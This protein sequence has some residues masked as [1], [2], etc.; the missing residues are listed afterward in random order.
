MHVILPLIFFAFIPALAV[1]GH[2]AYLYY[3]HQDKG[4][5]LSTFGFIWT[6]Y[7]AQS[8]EQVLEAL[9]PEQAEIMAA[10]LGRKAIEL[11]GAFGV[12]LSCIIIVVK[13]IAVLFSGLHSISAK[14]RRS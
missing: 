10:I 8:Y 14:R 2:D 13:L 11:T 7:H 12:L 9:T 1:L 4:F 3:E 6:E 5:M